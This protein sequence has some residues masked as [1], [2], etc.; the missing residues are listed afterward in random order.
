VIL[1]GELNSSYNIQNPKVGRCW[2]LA[3]NERLLTEVIA[4]RVRDRRRKPSLS[5]ERNHTFILEALPILPYGQEHTFFFLNIK[6]AL[7]IIVLS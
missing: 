1:Q 4:Q 6:Q 3:N 2:N 7:L 5:A